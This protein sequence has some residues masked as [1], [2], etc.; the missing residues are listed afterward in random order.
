VT[1]ED[2]VRKLA[3]E[4][5]VQSAPDVHEDWK[6]V[7]VLLTEAIQ[8]QSKVVRGPLRRALRRHTVDDEVAL[9]PEG[10]VATGQTG[11]PGNGDGDDGPSIVV[12]ASGN[13]GLVYATLRDER[14]TLEEIETL[15][16][17]LLEGLAAHEGIGFVMV[18]SKEH[19]PVVLG[20][21]GRAYLDDGRVEGKD[22]LAGFGPNAVQHLRRSDGFHDAP[23]ILVNSFYRPEGN[24]VAAF[25]EQIGSHGGMGGYQN[26]PLLLFPAEW[27]VGE[28]DLV[29][30]AAVYRQCKAWL[31]QLSHQAAGTETAQ[32]NA[33]Q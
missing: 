27:E 31:A 26:Q 3:K 23:D 9:G 12:L 10:V 7:N 33:V 19:G 32:G 22:P 5:R 24:E 15:Y 6:H 16:P 30:A 4:H 1:L 11:D 20:A 17:G 29:G 18:R 21:G 13:L 2:L 28:G 14:A 25:E 8:S